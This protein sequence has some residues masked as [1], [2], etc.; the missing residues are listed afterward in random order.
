MR[1]GRADVISTYKI[2]IL[3][4]SARVNGRGAVRDAAPALRRHRD[5][6]A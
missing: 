2:T 5:R 6:Q 4:S 1:E 3:E